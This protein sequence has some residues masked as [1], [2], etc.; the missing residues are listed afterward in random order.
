MVVAARWWWWW[1][2]CGLVFEDDRDRVVAATRREEDGGWGGKRRRCR[3]TGFGRWVDADIPVDCGH[4]AAIAPMVRSRTHVV[5][6][7]LVPG[8]EDLTGRDTIIVVDGCGVVRCSR[9]G[10]F[11]APDFDL[12]GHERSGEAV[13]PVGVGGATPIADSTTPGLELE[14]GGYVACVALVFPRIPQLVAD[15]TDLIQVAIL[16]VG[17]VDVRFC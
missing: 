7:P 14:R 3:G 16:R 10:E 1:W 17:E 5:V 11:G 6:V 2:W 8:V 12:G 9:R 15:V 4:W 13:F